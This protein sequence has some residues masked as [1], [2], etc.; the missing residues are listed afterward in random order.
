M[1]SDR[2]V[3]LL[4]PVD[5]AAGATVLAAGLSLFYTDVEVALALVG[6]DDPQE[7]H[8]QMVLDLCLSLVAGAP[9]PNI[10]LLGEAEAKA[11]DSLLVV[12][13]TSDPRSAAEA[14]VLLSAVAL[15]RWGD[16]DAGAAVTAPALSE[17]GHSDVAAAFLADRD[18]LIRER[19]RL[20]PVDV[21]PTVVVVAQVQSTWGTIEPICA[22]LKTRADVRLE[23]VAVESE[24]DVRE[25]STA[26]FVRARGYEPR[27]VAWLERQY[28][29]P[30]SGVAVTLFYDPWDGLRPQAA[31]ATFAAEF[32]VRVGYF[33]YSP[34]AAAGD[35]MEAMSYDLP[36]H[37]LAW[38]L[39]ARSERQ[40]ELFG[41]HC[42]VGNGQ[43]RVLG[44]PKMDRVISASKAAE[45]AHSHPWSEQAAG[46]PIILWN[47]HF[48]M[49]EGG[50]STFLTYLEPM[51]AYAA[52]HPEMFLLIRPHFRI[53][54]DLELAGENGREVAARLFAAA[55]DHRNVAIDTTP[56]YLESFRAA[57]VMVS[58][59]SSLLTEFFLTGRPL[60]YLHRPDGPG[61]NDD[62][63]YFLACDV[64][65]EWSDVQRF[66]DVTLTVGDL[67]R[68]R[69]ELAR[70]R[71]FV[72]EDGRSSARILDD[73]LSG[74]RTERTADPRVGQP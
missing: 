9:L 66:L 62:A 24:H 52:A 48:S 42:A 10:V 36:T 12:T 44:T 59:L 43:V 63:E 20:T 35:K 16:E 60:L 32:G 3:I 69:R 13:A 65:T 56:D 38:R 6:V 45:K 74:L 22:E 72:H 31:T 26:D 54:R 49:G 33:P 47:P 61:I 18:A 7:A 70:E 4:D 71:H 68:S 46:R 67:G 1:S 30:G 2:V 19:D 39:Y 64:A 5:P 37:R 25:G 58:D 34:N 55:T 21:V 40:R 73:I 23:V 27:D 41:A 50:W 53:L 29:D 28:A 51:V 8:G 57:D 17:A 14:I 15:K 11:T